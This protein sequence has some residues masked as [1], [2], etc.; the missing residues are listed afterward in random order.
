[1]AKVRAPEQLC[2]RFVPLH[3]TRVFQ[4]P[5][6]TWKTR[7][8]GGMDDQ[9]RLGS[10]LRA[11]LSVTGLDEYTHEERDLCRKISYRSDWFCRT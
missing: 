7:R 1:M 6:Y 5:T 2:A 8:C 9:G 10:I 3:I 11:G 4:D